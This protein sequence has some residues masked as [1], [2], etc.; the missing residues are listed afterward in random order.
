[1]SGI[2]AARVR[3]IAF[4]LLASLFALPAAGCGGD[5]GGYVYRTP[6]QTNDGWETASLADVEM[7]TMPI[8]EMMNGLLGRDDHYLHSIL[9]IRDAKLVFE[10][11]FSGE[12]LDLSDLSSG[13]HFSHKDFDLNTLH[14]LAS[15]SKSVTSILLG[16]AIDE[17]LV[18]DTNETMFSF[19]P[20]YSNLGDPAKNQITLAQMLAMTS[21]LPW[22]ESYAYT[23]PRNDLG[24]MAFFSEDPIAYVLGKSTVAPPGTQFIY[25]SGTT[26]L[27][28]EITRRTTGS[29]LESFADQHLFAPLGI[30]S[31]EWY[32]FPSDPDM[33]VASSALYLRPRDMAKIGQLYL[34]GGVWDTTRVVSESWVKASTSRAT[35][36]PASENPIPRFSD[37][38]GFQWW[39]GTFPK[40]DT[41]AYI[42]A[43]WGGQFIIVLPE[44]EMVVVMTAGDFENE[45]YDALVGLV[46]DY[47]LRAVR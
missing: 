32:G 15:V 33:A 30:D 39:L 8:V 3:I 5:D 9:V 13:V 41:D 18:G 21:G 45:D 34:D 40:E 19:F 17:G 1:V 10:E 2:R 35:D 44:R 12:D 36:V 28:G 20:D 29:T 7:D 23:D 42:A 27:L 46:D 22:N 16:I 37:G 38:Y 14:A 43:G 6:Q 11:Y 25:N 24:A 47:I 26:N 31:L 4:A